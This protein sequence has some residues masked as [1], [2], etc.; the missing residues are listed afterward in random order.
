MTLLKFS[1]V[2]PSYNQG[3]YLAATIESVLSQEGDFVLDYIITDGGSTDDSVAIIKHYAAQLEAGSWPIRC[4]GITYRWR[5]ERDRG[6]T[7]A[8][9]KGFAMATGGV[10]AWLN[11]DDT[12]TS[13][14]LARV[15]SVFAD[16]AIQIAYGKS[17]F[18]DENGT[19]IGRYPTEPFDAERLA[20]FNFIAQPSVFFRKAAVD[21]VGGPQIDLQYV[22]DFDLWIRMAQR[23]PFTYVPEFL[24]TFRLH[25]ESKTV[26]PTSALANYKEMLAIVSKHYGWSPLNRVYSYTRHLIEA[27]L[28]QLRDRE[29]SLVAISLPLAAAN[30]VRLNRG[31]RLADLRLVTPSNLRKLFM[32]PIELSKEY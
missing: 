2:T 27:K 4:Q 6:Q 26:S 17:H 21:A 7:D 18:T 15:A 22:M 30:Y 3:R 8:I 24:S 28:P 31:V 19:V 1:I 10:L 20:M 23:F 14:A 12:Y 13:G 9:R 29:L 11:S 16:P 5:S 32:T 25:D